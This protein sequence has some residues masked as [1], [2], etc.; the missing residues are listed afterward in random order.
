MTGRW[1]PVVPAAPLATLLLLLLQPLL[2]LTLLLS[3]VLALMEP[4][5]ESACHHPGDLNRFLACGLHGCAGQ[6][7]ADQWLLALAHS[8]CLHA[9]GWSGGLGPSHSGAEAFQASQPQGH[10]HPSYL[11]REP[12]LSAAAGLAASQH[13]LQGCSLGGQERC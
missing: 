4:K 12:H 9:A 8:Y 2:A 1:V 11:G 6:P 5:W 13:S 10:G 7:A 3:A